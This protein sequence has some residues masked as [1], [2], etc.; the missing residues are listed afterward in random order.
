MS[1]FR[2]GLE[3]QKKKTRIEDTVDSIHSR[4][5]HRGEECLRA[6]SEDPGIDWINRDEG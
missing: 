4:N 2:E 1:F 5:L 6:V 3:K